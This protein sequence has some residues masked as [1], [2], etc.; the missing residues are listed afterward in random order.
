MFV[1]P[2]LEV[3]PPGALLPPWRTFGSNKLMG[4]PPTASLF[5]FFVSIRTKQQ[6]V[7]QTYQFAVTP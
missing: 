7:T 3:H 6:L 1:W 4:K 2:L 5:T